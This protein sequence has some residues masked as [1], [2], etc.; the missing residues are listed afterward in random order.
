MAASERDDP[1]TLVSTD[2]LAAHLKDPDLRI[3]DASWHMPAEGRDA[4][5]EY[6]Q[7]HI[8][9]ARFFDIDDISDA[10]S[11]MPHMAPSTEKF[12]S[13]MRKM[14]VG[15]GHQVV[16]YDSKGL[17]SAARVWWLFRLMGKTDGLRA[18]FAPADLTKPAIT[19]CGSGITAAILA[20]ALTRI[21]K[22]DWSLYDGSWSE[23][24]MYDDLPIATGNT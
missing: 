18:A 21:G 12:M 9:G 10:R 22:T 4:R 24:G 1:K 3:L 23:W 19:T 15:D 5:A 2:W 8:P 17:F 14:G 7:S 6:A 11:E 16:V 20:L 13:R